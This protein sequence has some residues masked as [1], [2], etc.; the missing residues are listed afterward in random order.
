MSE[1]LENLKIAIVQ[2]CSNDSVDHNFSHIRKVL[3]QNNSQSEVI[4]F[5]ENCTYIRIDKSKSQDGFITVFDSHFQDIQPIVDEQKLTVI[6]GGVPINDGGEFFN[7][8]VVM[9]PFNKPVIAYR[10]VHLFDV[11][12][13]GKEIKESDIYSPGSALSFAE[14]CGWKTGFSICYDVRFPEVF[15]SYA[16]QGVELILVPSAFLPETGKAHW[17]SLLRARAIESQCFVVAPAQ[18]GVHKSV[19][20][21]HSRASYGHSMVIDPWGEVVV[22]LNDAEFDINHIVLSKEKIRSV[23]GQIPIHQHR[24]IK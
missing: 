16:K 11:S 19:D 22:D 2:M 1:N 5:P 23:R 20:S 4:C 18:A 21:E 3:E 9:R 17:E 8:T 12:V 13:K 7:A 10:K 15:L 6:L 14:L 24:R